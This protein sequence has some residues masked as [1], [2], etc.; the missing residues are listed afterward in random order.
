MFLL[1]KEMVNLITIDGP[2]A[3][4]KTSVSR[5]LAKEL[6]WNWLSTGVFY[7]GIAYLCHKRFKRDEIKESEVLK[8][9]EEEKGS[10]EVKLGEKATFF[11]WKGNSIPEKEIYS[12]PISTV[13]S[14]VSQFPHLREKIIP[15]QRKALK[16]HPQ[17]L[18]VEGRDCGSVVFP[19]APLKIYLTAS[20]KARVKRR[21]F[22]LKKE[23]LE[24][25]KNIQERD[26]KDTT[27]KHAPLICPEGSHRLDSSELTISQTV[28]QIKDLWKKIDF[29][30]NC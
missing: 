9:L 26:T 2:S 28:S 22:E 23:G 5:A 14:F 10:W 7:R 20:E 25:K 30:P 18:I 8:V 29:D 11:S 1:E 27:R 15:Y 24:V 17:G 3:S 16:K 13:A 21:S 12:L 19:E 4:G 6:G